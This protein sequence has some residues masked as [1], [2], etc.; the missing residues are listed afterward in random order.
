MLIIAGVL[1]FVGYWS[2]SG[3]FRFRG[4]SISMWYLFIRKPQWRT[5][6][7]LLQPGMNNPFK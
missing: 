6:W 3:E 1:I 4:C 5:G 7:N 2:V